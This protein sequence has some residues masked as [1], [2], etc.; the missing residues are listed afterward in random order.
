MSGND[1]TG[2]VVRPFA[3]AE[4][5]FRLDIDRVRPLQAVTDCGPLELIRRIEAGV[6]RVDDL[7]ETLFQGLIGGGATQ[8]EATVLIRDNFDQPKAGYAQFAPLAHEVL[9]AVVFG[10]EDDPLGERA[11]GAKTR[12]RSRKAKS[13]SGASSARRPSS[14][15]ARAKSD[16]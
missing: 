1:G 7:R 6:W 12:T 2:L 11:A 9:S 14:G 5:A 15:G 16:A 10:P 8:L 13:V 4:R 3:G